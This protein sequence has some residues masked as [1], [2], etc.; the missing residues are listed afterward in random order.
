MNGGVYS[1]V[2]AVGGERVSFD[3]WELIRPVTLTGYS[4]EDLACERRP[5]PLRLVDRSRRSSTRHLTVTVLVAEPPRLLFTVTLPGF[6]GQLN[7]PR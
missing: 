5:G 1:V 4:S 3:S 2:G 7:S 6:E